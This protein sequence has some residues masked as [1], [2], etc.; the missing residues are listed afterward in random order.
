MSL[1]HCSYWYVSEYYVLAGCNLF[2]NGNLYLN[3]THSILLIRNDNHF[4][5]GRC[6]Y[7]FHFT[8]LM[9]LQLS[10]H[11]TINLCEGSELQI[12]DSHCFHRSVY[13]YYAAA[14]RNL[15]RNENLH[16]NNIHSVLLIRH[17]NHFETDS[18]N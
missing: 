16:R 18:C 12:S 3:N 14:G 2:R 6:N 10:F 17:G 7:I 5:T 1:C 11:L 13:K 15:F 4:E 9:Y 8:D